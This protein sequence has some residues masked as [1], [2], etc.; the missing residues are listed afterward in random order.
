MATGDVVILINEGDEDFVDLYNGRQYRIPAGGRLMVDWDAMCLWMGH[1][2]ANDLDPRNRVR[3]AEFHRLRTRYGVDARALD[4]QMQKLPFDADSMFESMRPRLAAYD[5]AEQRIVTVS[6]DPTG[7]TLNVPPPM[8]TD[9]N[10]ILARM[11][12]ME[13]ELAN[14]RAQQAQIARAEQA[15]ND[16]QPISTDSPDL[17]DG[18]IEPH[19]TGIIGTIT[20]QPSAAPPQAPNRPDPRTAPGEDSPTRVRVS[21]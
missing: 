13:Q 10:V 12:Q 3:T 17:T 16:A 2:D 19:A 1:P 8:P 11:A 6:D 20:E 9:Q 7:E 14:L 15:K 4:F 21:G 18:H 5:S